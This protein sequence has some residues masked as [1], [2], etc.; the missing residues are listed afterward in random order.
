MRRKIIIAEKKEVG[1]AIAEALQGKVGRAEHCKGYIKVGEYDISW[2]FGHLL[3]LKQPEQVDVKYGSVWKMEDLPIYFD[4]WPVMLR[5]E[6]GH[7][8]GLLRNLLENADTVIHAG[9]P[10]D[11]GQLIVDEVL[12]YCKYTGNVMRV[13]INDNNPEAILKAFGKMRPNSEYRHMSDV[14]RARRIADATFGINLTRYY[15]G[16]NKSFVPTGRVLTVT[17]G[18]VVKRDYEV[19]NFVERIYYEIYA[20]TKYPDITLRLKRSQGESED[21]RI[22][23]SA[24]AQEISE[25][26]PGQNVKLEVLTKPE[27]QSPP[28]PLNLSVLQQIMADTHK[29]T[30]KATLEVT[31]TLRDKHR[32]ITYNRTDSRYLPEDLHAEAGSVIVNAYANLGEAIPALTDFT[33]ESKCYNDAR[34]TAHHAIIPTARK[35]DIKQLSEHELAVYKLVAKY[36]LLQFLSP[37]EYI[38]KKAEAKLSSGDS[39]IKEARRVKEQGYLAYFNDNVAKAGA[40]DDEFFKVPDHIYPATIL[41][42]SITNKTT[43][44]PKRYTYKSLLN[45]MSNVAKYV[46]DPEIKR[47]LKEKDKGKSEEHGSI[48]TPATRSDILDRLTADKAGYINV[49]NGKLISTD[50]GRAIYNTMRDD[51]KGPDVTAK[52]WSITEQIKTGDA[53]IDV[54]TNSVL[55]HV[56][57]VVSDK[58]AEKALWKKDQEPIGKCPYCGHDVYKN[59]SA[60]S[61]EYTKVKECDFFIMRKNKWF[62]SRGK[63]EISEKVM[64]DLLATGKAHVKNF[65]RKDGGGTYD[66][67]VTM[68]IPASH[69]GF[70][71]FNL[72]FGK[73]SK[74][75]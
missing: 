22:Y 20:R 40:G 38:Y 62:I 15:S 71:S 74:S 55:E 9:D 30:P 47:L 45:D 43:S 10:D 72:S 29:L 69:K 64:R 17:L 59:A 25:Q 6:Y 75:K 67:I 50:K 5:P 48:G 23:S 26:L 73:K 61:C 32:A 21:D 63:K 13:L 31:Q 2:C 44:P 8:L 4:P 18:L 58:S 34:V 56:R 41:S 42:S 39:L 49:K 37:A 36:Y 33:R 65:Q 12:E 35:I 3:A 11:E 70:P 57:S 52:W 46:T 66:G 7:R 53:T 24:E 19:E 54:L 1:E 28:L 14:A 16:L 51:V 60:Y 68:Q 27:L